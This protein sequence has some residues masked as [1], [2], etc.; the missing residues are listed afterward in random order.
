MAVF[1][2]EQEALSQ[3]SRP[4]DSV[5]AVKTKAG[6]L[7]LLIVALTV[8]VGVVTVLLISRTDRSGSPV[9]A[10]QRQVTFYGNAALPEIS[11]DGTYF[12]YARTSDTDRTLFLQ[13]FTGGEPIELL[14]WRYI[15]D[16]RMSPDGSEIAVAGGLGSKWGTFIIP[17]LGGTPRHIDRRMC[18]DA[19]IAWSPT[20]SII[21]IQES[22]R[23]RYR[24]SITLVERETGEA[25][26]IPMNVSFDWSYDLCWSPRGDRLLFTTGSADGNAV[27]AL[28]TS[29]TAPL[30]LL[31]GDVH[32]A[33]WSARADGVYYLQERMGSTDLLKLP[34]D[35]SSGERQ[36]NPRTLLSGLQTGR[37]SISADNRKLLY[38]KQ[39]SWSNL[40][41][42]T[43]NGSTGAASFSTRQLTQGT[44]E[45]QS[46]AFSPDGKYIAYAAPVEGDSHIWI[47]PALGGKARRITYSGKWHGSPA[48][49]PDGQN[50]ACA[51]SAD[52]QQYQVTVY[53]IVG[54]PAKR[55][56]KSVTHADANIAWWPS[57]NI[58]YQRPGNR[59]FHTL[60]PES[61]AEVPSLRTDT[62]GWI[63]SP[64]ASP[65][66][67]RLAV[68]WNRRGG[69]DGPG[70]WII[71]LID[72][73]W[74]FV[75]PGRFYPLGWS[76]EED[77]IYAVTGE[78]MSLGHIC[79]IDIQSGAVDTI[80]TL[81]FEG[82]SSVSMSPDK[83]SF[84]CAIREEQTDLWLVEDFDPD[85]K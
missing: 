40:W 52:G 72:S 83:R 7:A 70:P 58:V 62:L 80:L 29:G 68:W 60:D 30:K 77:S 11:P 10:R 13:D 9:V 24:D 32:S 45:I 46:P 37:F 22:C 27:W 55:F 42:V 66:G 38:N 20:S 15:L 73:S 19:S 81:P 43:L 56:E 31:D 74:T 78:G 82:V 57:R 76:D 85:M 49:S 65:S 41:A 71:S 16:V 47:V 44:S 3:P 8:V 51:S 28:D 54:G 39:T 64:K 14:R 1:R 75:C 53:S 5:R 25:R 61:E 2:R 26:Q 21:A 50:I 12:V 33:W 18:S 69:K 59:N 67:D 63:F 17:R 79:R 35:P 4:I 48:W 36:G 6:R 84:V 23:E 34:V